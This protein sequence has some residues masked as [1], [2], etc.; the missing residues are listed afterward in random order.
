M[1]GMM[2]VV[3]LAV[4]R[5]ARRAVIHDSGLRAAA[6]RGAAPRR[7]KRRCAIAALSILAFGIVGAIVP[8]EIG[9][10]LT[11]PSQ[12]RPAVAQSV[13]T[14]VLVDA[15][16]RDRQGKP[17]TDLTAEE[18]EVYENGVRQTLGAFTRVARGDGIGIGVGVKEPGRTMV[19]GADGAASRARDPAAT[20]APDTPAVTALVFDALSPDALAI[21]QQA[22]LT[23][24]PK[25]RSNDARVGVFTAEPRVR[26]LQTYTAD[27]ALVR[28][29]VRRV[30]PAG[31]I[32]HEQQR[33][34]LD[35]LSE[36]RKQIDLV[37]QGAD[38]AQAGGGGPDAASAGSIGSA[39]M[40]RRLL[41][42]ETKMLRAFETLDRDHRGLGTANALLAV[43]HSLAS[44]PGRKA[45][46]FFSQ[47][48]PASPALQG[49][50]QSV[51]E[52]ANRTNVTLY[53]VDASGLRAVSTASEYRK[54]LEETAD[55]RL[56]QLATGD[57]YLD[58]PVTEL[59]ERT[60][61]MLRFDPHGGLTRLAQDTGG[62]LVR[63]TNNLAGA[64]RRIDEDM[65]FHYMLSYSP[66]NQSFDGSFRA[67]EVKVR[68]P[69]MRVFARKGYRALR[70]VSAVPVLAYEAPALAA[71]D[72]DRVPNAFPFT[73]AAYSFP[74]P[75]R[76]GLS[77]LLVRLKTE[78]L[79]YRQD[80]AERT[81]TAEAV[82]VVRITDDAG[83]VVHKT[84]QEYQLTGKLEELDAAKRGE[85][86]FYREA[87]LS[88]GVY[89]VEAVVFDAAARRASARV[90]TLEVPRV[91]KEHAQ[92][93]SLVL[94]DRIEQV[95]ADGATAANTDGGATATTGPLYVGNLLVYPNAGEALSKRERREL[96]FYFSI[97][98]SGRDGQPRAASSAELEL[99][100]SGRLLARV[101][102]QLAAPDSGGQIQQVSRIPI[103]TLTPGA[104]ELRLRVND[105]SRAIERSTFFRLVE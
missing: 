68:R 8:F 21:C 88:P 3:S 100:A 23:V 94:V 11:E 22:A 101:P 44:L 84:S 20:I 47:G 18:F 72:A 56:R 63:D 25:A 61:D 74:D 95:A 62:F 27:P 17:V 58:R 10:A 14:A 12:P 97:Y 30:V 7:P 45:V 52:L 92:V 86:L 50:L 24:L 5:V 28:R 83:R 67:I 76:P 79:T 49:H 70:V 85:I 4:T 37:A 60:E 51:V 82:V 40:E 59:V 39:E 34:R 36:R 15:V 98:G 105:G 93:S 2:R 16:V 69:G 1:P 71:L 53:A 99:L 96:M 46:V 91:S 43:V 103:D 57:R 65:R 29:A 64:F 41:Q 38:S 48:L 104:Y 73:S 90:A 6:A 13:V 19:V 89:S 81:Y 87:E 80:A 54:Q 55:E 77:P 78:T 32:A 66:A 75:R 9:A 102:L 26:S 35:A 33:E 42:S 31:T